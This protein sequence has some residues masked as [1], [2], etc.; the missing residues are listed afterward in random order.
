MVV[1][2]GHGSSYP[3]GRQLLQMSFS[4][5]GGHSAILE[6]SNRG[7]LL[8]SA[9][10]EVIS[11]ST[12]VDAL[13]L[14]PLWWFV[15]AWLSRGHLFGPAPTGVPGLYCWHSSQYL[16]KKSVKILKFIVRVPQ[17]SPLG[18]HGCWQR[19]TFLW[20]SVHLCI[21]HVHTVAEIQALLSQLSRLF[22]PFKT[23]YNSFYTIQI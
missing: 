20:H 12:E 3:A 1:P 9:L 6:C 17:A 7:N 22:K 8:G 2:R 10:K 15:Q 5:S 13:S 16:N 14:V 19:F 11:A 4:D 21:S 23:I 18:V